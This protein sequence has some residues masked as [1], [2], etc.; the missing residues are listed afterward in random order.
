MFI[1]KIKKEY[2]SKGFVLLKK[3]LPKK[4]VKMFKMVEQTK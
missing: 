3:F 4:N 2:N 1:T